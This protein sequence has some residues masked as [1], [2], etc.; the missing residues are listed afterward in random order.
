MKFE[1]KGGDGNFPTTTFLNSKETPFR[2]M[3]TETD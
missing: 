1:G 3:V 2:R